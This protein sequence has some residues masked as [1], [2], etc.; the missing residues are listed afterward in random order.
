[1]VASVVLVAMLVVFASA[2]VALWLLA[3]RTDDQMDFEQAD[4]VAKPDDG[5]RLGIALGANANN[6]MM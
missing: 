5:L 2:G 1:M 4:G 6:G 3:R